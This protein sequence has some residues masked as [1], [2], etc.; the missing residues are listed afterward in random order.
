M[1]LVSKIDSAVSTGIGFTRLQ[2]RGNLP[3][4]RDPMNANPARILWQILAF[5]E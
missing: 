1:T 2:E 3:Q 5:E 4:E